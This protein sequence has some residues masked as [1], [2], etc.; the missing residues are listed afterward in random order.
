MRA[1]VR[2]PMGAAVSR[3]KQRQSG[4]RPR[5]RLTATAAAKTASSAS[6]AQPARAALDAGISAAATSS[7]A[8]GSATATG[9][10]S[11][12]GTPNAA[13]VARVPVRSDSLAAPEAQKTA[14][15]TSLAASSAAFT[16]PAFQQ[17][18]TI[19]SCT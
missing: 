7:S 4:R 6:A 15:R 11:G 18:W 17:N 19:A 10:V 2:H 1:S 5:A 8:A 14:A 12:A 3:P 13:A 9:P 16:Q